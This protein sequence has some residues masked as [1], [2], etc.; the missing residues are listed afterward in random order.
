MNA[1]DEKDSSEISYFQWYGKKTKTVIGFTLFVLI[2]LI[3]ASS[4]SFVIFSKFFGKKVTTLS[5]SKSTLSNHYN[6]ITSSSTNSTTS[7]LIAKTSWLVTK[8]ENYLPILMY[9]NVQPDTLM[10]TLFLLKILNLSYEYFNPVKF[11]QFQV[12]KLQKFYQQTQN[13]LKN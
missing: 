12:M 10:E 11:I 2:L 13:Q 6:P 3:I 7:P 9:H 4:I 5:S 1:L 8:D